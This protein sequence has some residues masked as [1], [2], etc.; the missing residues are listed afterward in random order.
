MMMH[1]MN[2]VNRPPKCDYRECEPFLLLGH[3]RAPLHISDLAP[4][5]ID[6]QGGISACSVAASRFSGNREQGCL[7]FVVCR[8]R[9]SPSSQ[10]WA[11]QAMRWS[12]NRTWVSIQAD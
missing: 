2:L 1:E 4:G 11:M 5:S 9:G 6:C 3:V 12:G 8:R 7:A 10:V